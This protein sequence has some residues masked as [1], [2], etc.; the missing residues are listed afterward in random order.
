M[1][2]VEEEVRERLVRVDDDSSESE[3]EPE[4]EGNEG[5]S[6]D[7]WESMEED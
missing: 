2:P 1:A 6:A 5:K 4:P 3:D 7:R